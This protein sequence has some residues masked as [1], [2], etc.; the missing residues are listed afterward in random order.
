MSQMTVLFISLH[1]VIERLLPPLGLNEAPETGYRRFLCA[2]F[3]VTLIY[4]NIVANDLLPRILDPQV[5]VAYRENPELKLHAGAIPSEFFAGVFRFGHAMVRHEYT[6]NSTFDEQ[7]LHK[8]LSQSTHTN[9]AELPVSRQ[10]AVDWDF[11][12]GNRDGVNL[13]R[14]IGPFYSH[15]LMSMGPKALVAQ[16]EIDVRGLPA[17]D[18]LTSTYTGLWSVPAL[19]K[20]IRSKLREPD[21]ALPDLLPDFSIWSEAL[22]TWFGSEQGVSHAGGETVM[23]SRLPSL[24]NDPPLAFFVL[25]EAAHDFDET[26]QP[27]AAVPHGNKLFF[28]GQGGRRLGR[29]G[30]IL[31]ADAFYSALRHQPFGPEAGRSMRARIEHVCTSLLGEDERSVLSE[32]TLTRDGATERPLNTMGQLL[33]LMAELRAFT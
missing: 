23:V 7:P 19:F 26:G 16:T 27:M 33:E 2:R 20:E 30:S 29:F 3:I 10:W 18:F 31:V 11:F 32:V 8:A 6:T 15:G 17:R 5:N 28:P 12:F 21:I 14:R 25:F 22:E 13:S 1:N 4:R 9:Y 24:K